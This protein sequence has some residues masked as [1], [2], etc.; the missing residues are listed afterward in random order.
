MNSPATAAMGDGDELGSIREGM[1]ANMIV[2]GADPPRDISAVRDV[3]MVVTDGR[4]HTLE[5]LQRR[6]RD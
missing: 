3:H 5:E 1:V 4:M 6:P 2:F